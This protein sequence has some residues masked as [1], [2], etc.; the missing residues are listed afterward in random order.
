MSC[1]VFKWLIRIL[2]F[3]LQ[4]VL[5]KKYFKISLQGDNHIGFFKNNEPLLII[6]KRHRI[7][8]LYLNTILERTNIGFEEFQFLL[9]KCNEQKP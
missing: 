4:K 9:K 6:E 1:R 7:S 8:D 5:P 2:G 3:C